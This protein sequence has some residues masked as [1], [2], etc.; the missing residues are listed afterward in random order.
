M[1][2]RQRLV[3]AS[4]EEVW[5][6][7]ADA[8]GYGEWVVGTSSTRPMEG[9]WPGVGAQIEYRIPM[10]RWSAAG[11]TTVR[12]C[13]RPHHL[14]LEADS[15][16]LGTARIALEIRPWGEETLIVF[17]EHPLRGPGG[18]LHNAAVD[19]VAQIRNRSMLSRLA[20]LVEKRRTAGGRP[21]PGGET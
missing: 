3:E 15:G 2:V 17:E 8:S 9:D 6:V 7:L 14:E 4:P 20:K 16:R 12:F 13:E 18:L 5:D 11:R 19:A 1:A 21:A 10:G